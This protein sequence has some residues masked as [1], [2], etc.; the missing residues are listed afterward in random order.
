MDDVGR[1]CPCCEA[2]N[3]APLDCYND[4]KK[5]IAEIEDRVSV[6]YGEHMTIQQIIE[7]KED[8]INGNG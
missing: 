5:A 3:N 2:T 7:E 8:E 4:L 1:V 6:R